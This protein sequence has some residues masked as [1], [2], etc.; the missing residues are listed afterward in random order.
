MTHETSKKYRLG[1]AQR[2]VNQLYA[3]LTRL[4]LGTSH[5]HLLTVTGRRSGLPR[6]TPVDVMDHDG[7][8]WLVAPYG[9]VNWVKNLRQAGVAELCRGRRVRTFDAEEVGPE[10]AAPVIRQYIAHVP[11]TRAYWGVS[12]EGTIDEL[13]TEARTHPVFRLTAC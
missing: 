10:L 11:V 13:R 3:A 6:T 1:P 5:R 9:E 7:V 8:L 2:S 4:R 12:S